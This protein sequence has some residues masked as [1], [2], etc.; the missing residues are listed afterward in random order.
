[1]KLIMEN[2]RGYLTEEEMRSQIMAYLEENNI[3]LTEEEIEEAMPRWMKKLGTGM[4]LAGTLASANPAHATADIGK[5]FNRG[6]GADADQ[7]QQAPEEGLSED[8]K[9][10]TA[11]QKVFDDQQIAMDSASLSARTGLMDQGHAQ[12]DIDA[13]IKYELI[14][15]HIYATATLK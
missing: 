8:G 3:T 5:F 11:K 4:A 6:R 12:T 10:F 14:G 7:Q 9:S 13:A 1:M 15:G 2:W